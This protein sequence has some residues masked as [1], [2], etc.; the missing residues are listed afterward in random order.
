MAFDFSRAA[1][2]Q[3][4]GFGSMMGGFVGPAQILQNAPFQKALRESEALKAGIFESGMGELG[5]NSRNQA[6]VDANLKIADDRLKA[7]QKSSRLAGISSLLAAGN[8]FGGGTNGRMAGNVFGVGSDGVSPTKRLSI[9]TAEQAELLEQN[10]RLQLASGA[11]GAGSAATAA[12][13]VKLMP[14]MPRA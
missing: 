6:T 2:L 8:A 10:R 3:P 9:R 14:P 4:D 13:L 12:E 11:F 1:I 5:A 7:E